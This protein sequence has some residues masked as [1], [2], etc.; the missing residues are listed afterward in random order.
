M[1]EIGPRYSPGYLQLCC[2]DRAAACGGAGGRQGG[3]GMPDWVAGIAG[4][5]VLSMV[6]AYGFLRWRGRGIGNPC[7]PRAR[8]WAFSMMVVTAIA[9]VGVGLLVVVATRQV[10]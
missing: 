7:G 8:I 1:G 9:S 10:H 3:N 4:T 6:L 5:F 2:R